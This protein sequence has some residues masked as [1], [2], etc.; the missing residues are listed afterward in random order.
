[1]APPGME[2]MTNQLQSMFSNLSG[3]RKNQ[4]HE[5]RRCP[6]QSQRRRSRSLDQRR[7]TQAK[8]Y[9]GGRQN[10]II[11]IDE[12]DKVAKRGEHSSADVLRKG[13]SETLLPIIEGSTVNTKFGMI[14]TDHILFYR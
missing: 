13:F 12:I 2:D 6:S 11:F 5:G 9:S 10:G 7:R 4:A 3:D 8:G 1:M 14:K